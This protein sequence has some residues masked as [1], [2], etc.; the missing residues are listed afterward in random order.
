[1]PALMQTDDG[2]V[3]LHYD[4]SGKRRVKN[5]YNA[6]DTTKVHF[7]TYDGGTLLYETIGTIVS[8]EEDT[9]IVEELIQYVVDEAGSHIGF[10][11]DGTEYYFA[12]NLQGDVQRI[13]TADGTL[14]GEYHYDAWGNILNEDSL[15]AIAQLNPIREHRGTVLPC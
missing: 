2:E 5:L 13:Y 7:Y 14:V 12:K 9:E 11:H 1:M 15:T 3:S 8:T 6:T 4:E 10:I